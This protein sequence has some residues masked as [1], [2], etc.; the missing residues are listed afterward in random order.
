MGSL[1]SSFL[2]ALAVLLPAPDESP[3]PPR[4]LIVTPDP[5]GPGRDFEALLSDHDIPATVVT[6]EVATVEFARDYD[7]LMVTGLGRSIEGDGVVTGYDRPVL[8]I[9]PYG[10]TYFGSMK[11]KN[12]HPYT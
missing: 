3:T 10:C 11:L 7:L 6:W 8:G 5:E 12:G 1:F 4:V 9:G 2:L